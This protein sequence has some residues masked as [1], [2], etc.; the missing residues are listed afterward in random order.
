MLLKL[1]WP[2]P[3]RLLTPFIH[4][5]PY[6]NGVL[7]CGGKEEEG[8][9]QTKHSGEKVVDGVFACKHAKAKLPTTGD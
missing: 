8:K 5:G 2:L 9:T 1:R 3:L 6:P 7:A 4:I